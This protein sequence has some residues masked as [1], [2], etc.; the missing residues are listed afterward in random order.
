[1]T[2][3]KNI[4]TNRGSSS[5]RLQQ[6]LHAMAKSSWK[7]NADQYELKFFDDFNGDE[8]DTNYWSHFLGPGPG[9]GEQQV[10]TN[11]K[12]NS[13]VEDSVLHVRAIRE[14]INYEGWWTNWTSARLETKQKFNF[15]YGRMS[16]R[17]R[18][19]AVPGPFSAV[20]ALSEQGA[21]PN[22]GWPKCGEIDFFEMQALWD[23][24]P[25]TLH[26]EEH[27]YGSSMSFFSYKTFETVHDWHEY[28]VEWENDYIAFYHDGV[29]IGEYPKP[30][31]KTVSR[32]NW[33]FDKALDNKFYFII[34]NAMDP[35]WGTKADSSL[36]MHDVEVDWIKLEQKKTSS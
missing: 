12:K 30:I 5:A 27:C 25:S 15:T 35:D 8:I 24:T 34:N 17:I 28:G 18:C 33:P 20:W 4:L 1:M 23:Y 7:D 31:P 9:N 3:P 14:P 26:F 22:I 19:K 21:D 29:R 13:F 2:A 16:T 32:T 6:S 36:M 11:S 10:Y